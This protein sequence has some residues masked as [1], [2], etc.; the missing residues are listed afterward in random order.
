M[1]VASSK[2][3]PGKSLAETHPDVAAQADGWD[4]ATVKAGSNKKH[5][6]ICGNGHSWVT[7]V[8]S[9]TQGGRKNLGTGCAVCS[10]RKLLKGFN[11]LKTVNPDLAPEAL[12]WEP[13]EFLRGSGA[14]KSWKCSKN[15]IWTQ[16]IKERAC[17]GSG[18]P[19]CNGK[20]VD[21]GVNDLATLFPEIAAQADGWDPQTVF[22]QSNK[23]VKWR[24]SKG[25]GWLG[26]VNN[27]TAGGNGCPICIGQSVLAGFNDLSTTHPTVAA[28][29]I[30]W[31]P[32][33]VT[34]GT[35]VKYEWQCEA[36]HS[37]KASP[38]NRALNG[39]GCPTC[40]KYGFDP[41]IP[42]WIY[43]L[44]SE[45]RDMYQIGI[46]NQPETRLAQ[47]FRKEWAL[48]ELRGPMDGHLTQKLET[49]C[50]HA[51]ERR[52]AILGH[53]AGIDKFDGYTEAWTKKSLN[54]TSIKQILDWVYEDEGV[55]NG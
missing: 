9:R 17:N 16:S 19:V 40:A 20:V 27:R 42:G 55:R 11:D 53:K 15:H 23:K 47:H 4:P 8:L 52:G 50:L 36:G 6:W 5:L 37:W 44:Q 39:R 48:E 3:Q 22:A 14:R 51:L 1:I 35:N 34:A 38:H 30:G 49:D 12:D 2:P 10:G 28:E 41:N 13:S 46:S 33:K 32:T 21:V 45:E 7:S 24:C 54:V 25:H 26:S 18:C 43:F 31:D 29:A